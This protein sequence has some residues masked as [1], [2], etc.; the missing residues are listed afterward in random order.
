MIEENNR[1]K[2]KVNKQATIKG[3]VIKVEN[4]F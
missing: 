1:P 3:I 2:A 4:K